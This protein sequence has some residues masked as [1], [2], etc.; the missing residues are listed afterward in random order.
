[1]EILKTRFGYG[2]FRLGQEKIIE[3]VLARKDTFVLMPTGGGKSLCFQIPALIFDGLTLVISP[4]IALMKDQVDGLK[5]N[6]IEAEFLN[7]TLSQ[8]KE[9]EIVQSL[10]E[11]KLKLLYVAPERI[12]SG[13]GQF[14]ELLKK[15]KISLIA[16]DEAHCISHWGHD[17]RREYLRLSAFKDTF[18]DVPVI[19]LTATADTLTRKDILEKLKLVSPQTYI[20]SFNRENIHYFIEP[21]RQSYRRLTEYLNNH[22]DDSGI[23]YTLSRKSAENLAENLDLDGFSVKPYHAGL[24]REERELHQDL[25]IK[26]EIR[27]IVATIA[28]GL[29]VDKSNVRFVIHMDV[30]KNI[31]GYYQETGR[32]GR[33]GVKSE[34]ILFYSRGDIMKLRK[35]AEVENNPKQTAIML[36]K[37]RK[38]S[39]LA[40]TR[41]CRRK[42]ILNYFGEEYEGNCKSCDVCLT[43]VEKFDGTT[44][45]QKIL[46]AVFRLEE[47]FGVGYLV[48]FLQGKDTA[49]IWN[50]HKSIKT[51]GVSSD[52]SKEDL[53]R[54]IYDLIEMCY[55]TQ[56]TGKYPI[57]KLTEKSKAVLKGEEKVMLVKSTERKETEAKTVLPYEKELFT[58]LKSVRMKL[59]AAEKVPAYIIF[60]DATLIEL[61][62]YLPQE[63]SELSRISGFGEIKTKKYGE[64]F[65]EEVKKY[66]NS[67]NLKSRTQE[68]PSY[69]RREGRRRSYR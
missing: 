61:A 46:S 15:I 69:R 4:L 67:H 60:S 40:E 41:I 59:A 36:E 32:A 12:Y 64:I 49:K 52:I 45:A 62:T 20:S 54:Y 22:K 65:L 13:D 38:M 55:L 47:R 18:P 44:I 8:N 31:E 39:K 27:I 33:D 2:E 50:E 6:G 48:D 11:N 21:K 9:R 26:D 43:D 68:K 37:L 19:A 30:P 1:M 16:I 17:F 23:I 58:V 56:D 3:S 53:R 24:T 5:L 42:Y 66:C 25:F 14:L 29:G 34:A 35:F 28:F 57:L 63:F 51:F 7:S 10:L